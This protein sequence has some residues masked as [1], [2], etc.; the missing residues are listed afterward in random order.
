MVCNDVIRHVRRSKLM[1]VYRPYAPSRRPCGTFVLYVVILTS[2][3]SFS[4]VITSSWP[5]FGARVSLSVAVSI[6]VSLLTPPTERR[7]RGVSTL[8]WR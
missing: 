2:L 8:S 1:A 5:S 6:F 3:F 4:Y 7:A